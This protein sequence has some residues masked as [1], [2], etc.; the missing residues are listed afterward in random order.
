MKSAEAVDVVIIGGGIVGTVLAKG[1]A[2]KVGLSV[3]L[4]D[5]ADPKQTQESNTDFNPFTDTRVIALARRTVA[6]LSSVGLNLEDVAKQHN[7]E[8]PPE[9]KHI[10]VSD[11]GHVGLLNL[12]SDDYHIDAFGQV[13]S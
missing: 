10:E 3:A 7:G 1:L 4:I 13:V 11:K 8:L 2:E 9:I 6:E 5:A 12:N